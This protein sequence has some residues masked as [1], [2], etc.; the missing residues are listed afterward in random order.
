MP[1]REAKMINPLIFSALPV[2]NR[3]SGAHNELVVYSGGI[4]GCFPS[5][6]T[7]LAAGGE[8]LGRTS[9]DEDMIPEP[10]PP[11]III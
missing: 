9:K 8:S 2:L 3:A 11:P 5:G 4:V 7:R 10:S 1:V 6:P